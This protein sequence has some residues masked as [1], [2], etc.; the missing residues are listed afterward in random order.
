MCALCSLTWPCSPSWMFWASLSF[1]LCTVSEEGRKSLCPQVRTSEFREKEKL[2]ACIFEKKVM[3]FRKGPQEV[4]WFW[5]CIHFQTSSIHCSVY[6]FHEFQTSGMSIWS[7][8]RL[9]DGLFRDDYLRLPWEGRM[10]VPASVTSACFSWQCYDPAYL[11]IWGKT[12]QWRK[13]RIRSEVGNE[14]G[15]PRNYSRLR[16]CPNWA[17]GKK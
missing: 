15:S 3:K 8:Q 14:P 7:A 16:C 12:I 13:G 9:W 11:V 2:V 1:P 5:W 17:P 10:T 6:S 4:R